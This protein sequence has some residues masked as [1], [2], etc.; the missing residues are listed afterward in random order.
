MYK[1]LCLSDYNYFNKYYKI[2]AIDL[3]KQQAFNADLKAKQQINLKGNQARDSNANTTMFYILEE[4]KETILDLYKY[5]IKSVVTS[6]CF[7]IK[8]LSILNVNLS[9]SQHNKLK[10]VTENG[11]DI[12]FKKFKE[13]LL[14]I[15]MINLHKLLLTNGKVSRVYKAFA[16]SS[17]VNI[18]LS[19][20]QLH[21]MKKSGSFLS[22]LLERLLK[23]ICF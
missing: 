11:T 7:S 10:S 22:K 2:S 18:K 15:L 21:K 8:W 20:T 1:S 9:N 3:R 23:M 4:V 16:N 6:F 17:S 5:Y 13:I 12:T 19:K 14:V